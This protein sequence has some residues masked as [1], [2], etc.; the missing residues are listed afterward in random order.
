VCAD[1]VDSSD[2]TGRGKTD[3]LSSWWIPCGILRN[4][5]DW[6]M[7]IADE[8]GGAGTRKVL[9]G[10]QTSNIAPTKMVDVDSFSSSSRWITVGDS[11]YKPG[12]WIRIHWST[13]VYQYQVCSMPPQT[14]VN[15]CKD[16][17]EFPF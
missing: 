7:W 15:T 9:Y 16:N 13:T 4:R 1:P 17:L 6:W 14:S 10:G 8:P 3:C 5:T 2:P 11:W 12:Y